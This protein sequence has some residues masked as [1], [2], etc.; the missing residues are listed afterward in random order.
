[1]GRARSRCAPRDGVRQ[2]A[3]EDLILAADLLCEQCPLFER[4]AGQVPVAGGV[5]HDGVEG[6]QPALD[7]LVRIEGHAAGPDGPGQVATAAAQDGNTAELGLLWD[8]AYRGKGLKVA[9]I[10]KRGPADRK[11]LDLKV[12]DFVV[13]IDG[14]EV[15]DNANLAK[16]LNGKVG[17]PV[18]L[19]VTADPNDPKVKKRRVELSCIGRGRSRSGQ[20]GAGELMYE[21][22]VARNAARVA[23]KSGGKLGYIHI[24]SSA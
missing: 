5:V 1:M 8:E 4:L 17:E 10:L 12:G 9:E 21:R 2:D 6:L 16:L 13:A 14:V 22:W 24:P 7:R 20:P 11:G 15:D 18:M 23:E 19:E 3:L